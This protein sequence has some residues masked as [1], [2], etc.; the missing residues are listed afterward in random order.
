[1]SNALEWPKHA[2]RRPGVP[3]A[4]PGVVRRLRPPSMNSTALKCLLLVALTLPSLAADPVDVSLVQL[5]A[6]PT[7][8]HQKLVRV[9]AFLNIEFEGDALYLHKEDYLHRISSNA[10]WIDLPSKIPDK[11]AINRKYVIVEAVFRADV[12]G[13]MGMFSGTLT[14]TKRLDLWSDPSDPLT[15]QF[16]RKRKPK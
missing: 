6:N 8:F 13:H 7:E 11:A 5:I 15:E 3:A 2:L 9:I 12:R 14:D 4:E 1:M 16:K 10:V